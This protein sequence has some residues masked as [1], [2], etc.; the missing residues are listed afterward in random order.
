MVGGGVHNNKEQMGV[1][2]PELLWK[3]AILALLPHENPLVR[4]RGKE[5]PSDLGW[6]RSFH[7]CA[8]GGLYKKQRGKKKEAEEAWLG[9]GCSFWCKVKE[10]SCS[11]DDF[12]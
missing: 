1:P 3:G 9:Q 4:D 8:R 11:Y 5:L 12:K 2:A 10:I 7:S 6:T